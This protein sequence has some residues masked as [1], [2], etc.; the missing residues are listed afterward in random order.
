ML[1]LSKNTVYKDAMN[2]SAESRHKEMMRKSD[3]KQ[4]LKKDSSL[5]RKS[6]SRET[7]KPLLI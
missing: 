3:T 1:L 6:T 2:M 5:I 4:Q 7:F